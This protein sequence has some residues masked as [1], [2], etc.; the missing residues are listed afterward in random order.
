[1]TVARR[2]EPQCILAASRHRTGFP[3]E[4]LFGQNLIHAPPA[5]YSA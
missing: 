4:E 5:D 1:M 2:R 3:A